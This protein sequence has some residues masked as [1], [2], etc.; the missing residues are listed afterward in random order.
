MKQ[1]EESSHICAERISYRYPGAEQYVFRDY[2]ASF[3]IEGKT[4]I[5]AR[6]GSGKT[7]LLLLL[8]GLLRPV[9][10]KILVPAADGKPLSFSMVF[11]EDRLIES[12]SV[13][14]NITLAARGA[15]GGRTDDA[16]IRSGLSACRDKKVS[17]LSGGEKRRCAIVRAL[18]AAYDVLI[19]DEPF[20]GLDRG[21]KDAMMSLVKDFNAQKGL[22]LVTHDERE[23]EYFGCGIRRL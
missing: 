23:A 3:P 9:S 21:T 20:T 13:L 6:S 22:I 17:A 16:L 12:Q 8:T 1:S 18:L 14:K 5:L 19:L 2:S 7:T 4:A 15:R 11:Q 10:G